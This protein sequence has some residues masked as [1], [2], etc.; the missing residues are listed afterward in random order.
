MLGRIPEVLKLVR[1]L[2]HVVQLTDLQSVG[3]DELVP[4][5]QSPWRVMYADPIEFTSTQITI[6]VKQFNGD[7]LFLP[8]L[9]LPDCDRL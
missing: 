3:D 5:T 1:V 8:L 7:R 9:E 4:P 2:L 6:G